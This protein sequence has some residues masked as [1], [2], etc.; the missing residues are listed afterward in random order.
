MIKS[1][2]FC[3]AAHAGIAMQNKTDYCCC[4]VNKESWKTN[5][6]EVMHAATHDPGQAWNSYSRKII[7]EV[8]D[9]G[10]QHPSCQVCWDLESAG[11]ASNRMILNSQFGDIEIL[12]DQPQVLIIKPGNTCNLACRMCNPETSSSWYSDAYKLEKSTLP[13]AEYTRKFEIIRNS[14]N[15]DNQNFWNTFKQWL[16]NIKFIDIYGGEPF[17]APALF[18]LL[19]YGVNNNIANNVSLGIHTNATILNR[20]YL[21]ILSKYK[22]VEFRVSVDSASP[23]Q[24]NYIR[25]RG[26]FEDIISNALEMQEFFK[27]FAHVSFGITYTI[28]PINVYYV[29]QDI[30]LLEQIF[31]ETNVS[32]NIVTTPEY[33]IRHLPIPVKDFLINNINDSSV[34]NFLK[35]TIPGCDIEWPKF[36]KVTDELDSIR[37]QSFAETFPEWW[38]MLEPYWVIQ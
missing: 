15:R 30:K 9:N 23:E 13:F 24:N 19:E 11:K 29:S 25:H 18:D 37:N 28:T 8:L 1:K 20:R 17:L 16:P 38:K 33:D 2:T 10:Q 27:P 12:N 34:T 26:N 21:E 35:Q 32:T 4:N 7:K 14:F 31:K 6:H 5:E 3:I 36:C 22:K